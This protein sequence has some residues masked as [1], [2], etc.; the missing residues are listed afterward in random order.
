MTNT[1]GLS[2]VVNKMPAAKVVHELGRAIRNGQS[3]Y[4]EALVERLNTQ[5]GFV[6]APRIKVVTK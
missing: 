2:H 3:G 6:N 5:K 4:Q 1:F